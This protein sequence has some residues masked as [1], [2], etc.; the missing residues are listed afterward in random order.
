MSSQRDDGKLDVTV[1]CLQMLDRRVRP[2]LEPPARGLLIL[3]AHRPTVSCSRYL[4]NT[5]GEPWLWMDRRKLDDQALAAIV[6]HEQVE[7]FVLYKEGVPAGYC[8]LDLRKMPDLEL[9]YFGILPEFIG[10]RLGP[11][12]LDQAIEIAW[13]RNPGR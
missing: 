3:R 12:L 4:Y 10:Q 7:V 2:A 9:A 8:E 11:Y 5:F 13:S 1:T 6:Q